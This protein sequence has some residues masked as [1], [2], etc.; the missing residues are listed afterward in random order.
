MR[1]FSEVL[2]YLFHPLFLVTY[3]L[4]ILISIDPFSFGEREIMGE[5][6]LLV[7]T[8]I[9][10]IF[11]PLISMLVMRLVGFIDTMQLK[12][13]KERIGPLIVTMVFYTW[14]Y[15]N[16]REN[17]DIPVTFSVLTMGSI[18]AL[19][20]AFLVNVF[21]KISLH[22]TGLGGL[23]GFTGILIFAYHYAWIRI[24]G[25]S[26][27]LGVAFFMLLIIS[28]CVGT[29]RMKLKAHNLSQIYGGFMIGLLGQVAAWRFLL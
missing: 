1:I 9:Y 26:F 5:F 8:V 3:G 18:I 11:F 10:T 22:S 6:P 15:V 12:G 28:G 19:G 29:A 25:L 21:D 14:M 17:P 27:K 23:V 4:I 20:L 16:V 7:I 24:G 2:F 13:H